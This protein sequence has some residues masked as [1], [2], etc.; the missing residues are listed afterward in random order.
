MGLHFRK[1]NFISFKPSFH[2]FAQVLVLIKQFSI[3]NVNVFLCQIP[4][5]CFNVIPFFNFRQEHPVKTFE[6]SKLS[7]LFIQVVTQESFKEDTSDMNK[8]LSTLFPSLSSAS[9][10]LTWTNTNICLFL[11]GMI[12]FLE[13]KLATTSTR[14]TFDCSMF[15]MCL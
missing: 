8:S 11:L 3:I 6:F 4:H 12:A 15:W 7:G 5:A 13:L 9:F 14:D 10:D 1:C 2:K